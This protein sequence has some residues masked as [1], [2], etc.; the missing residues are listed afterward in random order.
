LVLLALGLIVLDK[1][2]VKMSNT[3]FRKNSL[4]RISSP[5]QL[6]DY[7]KVSNPS[8][9]IV[10]IALFIFLAAVAIWGMTGSMPTSI[11]LQGVT[12]GGQVICYLNPD[13]AAAVKQGREVSIKLPN[14]DEACS[15]IVKN[16]GTMPMSASEISAELKSDYLI[17]ALAGEGFAVKVVIA[18]D[19]TDVADGT[20]LDVN[21]I[22]DEVRPIDFL[23][24]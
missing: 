19:H 18:L 15:G 14:Q 12:Q 22:T 16:V 24:K 10:L 8:I 17:Q 20:M 11:N 7:I 21:I 2:E 5:E 1:G 9:W 23:L 4:D 13:D 6:N 3:L